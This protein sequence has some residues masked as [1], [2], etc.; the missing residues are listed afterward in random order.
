[1]TRTLSPPRR[2]LAVVVA[3]ALVGLGVAWTADRD[4]VPRRRLAGAWTLRAHEGLGVWVDVF[5]WTEEFTESGP[6]VGLD[7]LD[8]MADAGIETI[9]LQTAHSRSGTSGVIEPDRLAAL[10]ERAHAVG[11]RVVAWYLPTLLDVDADL[12]RLVASADLPV[13]GLGVDIEAVEVSDASER[14][15][16]L[17][18]LTER[19]RAAVGDD[20]ALAAITP[21]PT[22]LQVV[23]P[24]FWPDFPWVELA[25]AYDV[26]LP[27][28]YW[29][30]R[31]E[32]LRDG[33][34]YVGNDIDRLR[35]ATG[36]ADIPIHVIGG[37]ADALPVD[38][39]EGM[40]RAILERDAVGGSLYDWVTSND[41]QWA[42]LAPLRAAGP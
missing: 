40:A 13:D 2:A 6:P 39:V 38:Q 16:R 28:S 3:L 37:I 5:D 4:E 36:D 1:M 21:S 27:M 17:L 34:V 12:A 29:S 20:R 23:N 31:E 10:I 26:L 33:E 35:A 24:A 18:D 11:L 19:L 9:Y 30:I 14:N 7:D 41:A 32:A 15:A 8:R 25:D 22:H 42:A